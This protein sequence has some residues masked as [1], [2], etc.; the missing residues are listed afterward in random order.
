MTPDPAWMFTPGAQIEISYFVGTFYK[1]GPEDSTAEGEQDVSEGRRQTRVST[2]AG[3]FKGMVHI[4]TQL[5]GAMAVKMENGRTRLVPATSIV[6]IDILEGGDFNPD[7]DVCPL[8]G[9]APDHQPVN[10]AVYG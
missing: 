9:S 6:H 5:G 7:E 1:K 2:V 3:L 4:G 10:D 8:C